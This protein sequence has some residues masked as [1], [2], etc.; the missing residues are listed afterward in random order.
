MARSS[1][2]WVKGRSGNPRGRPRRGSCLADLLRREL[3]RAGPAGVAQKEAIVNK[4]VELAFEGDLR[5]IDM[6]F[7]RLEGRPA[8]RQELTGAEGAPLL[9]GRMSDDEIREHLARVLHGLQE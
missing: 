5:A 2:T 4:L 9:V 7:D 3:D 8:Q 1:S 6:I